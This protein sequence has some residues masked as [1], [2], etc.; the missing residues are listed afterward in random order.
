MSMFWKVVRSFYIII[1]HE[2]QR[3]ASHTYYAPDQQTAIWLGKCRLGLPVVRVASIPPDADNSQV[4][5]AVAFTPNR[6]SEGKDG[7]YAD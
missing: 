6:S 7:S 4:G 3:Y 1:S 5:Y 2:N